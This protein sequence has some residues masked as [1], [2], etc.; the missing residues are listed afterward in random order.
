M[1]KL[2]LILG[3][4]SLTT[5]SFI[6]CNSD[7]DDNNHG[8]STMSPD[9]LPVSA[10][11]LVSTYFSGISIKS[12]SQSSSPNIYNSVYKALLTNGFEIDFDK[13][14]N[15]TEIES[16]HNQAIPENFLSGEVPE[17]LDYVKSSYPSNWIVAIEKE[18]Y[19]Y[20]V[21][22]NNDLDLIF[23]QN[24][25][26]VGIDVDNDDNETVISYT[27]LPQAAQNFVTTNFAG[28]QYVTVKKETE[29]G[30]TSYKAYLSTG[31]KI[32]FDSAGNWTEIESKTNSDIPGTLIPANIKTYISTNYAGYT[33]TGIE[34][35]VYGYNVEI[36]KG[37]SDIDL[38]F[39][40][41]GT[42]LGIDH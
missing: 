8:Q 11:N 31:Y 15:W 39:D 27:S 30:K 6:A 38:K 1:K 18:H 7:N 41:N 5:L 14:G 26:F 34:K 17:I 21:E 9:S 37:V 35:E 19:G 4:I 42:F 20:S 10:K 25:E 36:V 3:L 23:N 16:E 40:P 22:L 28:S 29:A 13:N 33:I 24:R 12:A 32:E 2:F